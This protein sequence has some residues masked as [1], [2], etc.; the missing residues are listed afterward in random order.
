MAEPDSLSLGVA[1]TKN[2]LS[3]L[4]TRVALERA[5]VLIT[6]RGKPMARLVPAEPARESRHLAG[7]V[8]W[9]N[10]R[11]P[12]PAAID[13]IASARSTHFPRFLASRARPSSRRPGPTR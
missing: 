9:L 8:G 10:D 7:V 11:S 13:A 6:R 1:E 2:R 5:T 3:E 12:F 4:L